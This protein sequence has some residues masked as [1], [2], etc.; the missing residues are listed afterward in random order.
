MLL[1]VRHENFFGDTN[2][3]RNCHFKIFYKLAVATP[4]LPVEVLVVPGFPFPA[5]PIFNGDVC[6]ELIEG[7]CPT[8]VGEFHRFRIY[9]DL[10]ATGLPPV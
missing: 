2:H 7:S 6:S 1:K 4:V 10:P 5:I 8:T 3:K 9:I